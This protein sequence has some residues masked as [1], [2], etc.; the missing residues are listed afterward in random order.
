VTQIVSIE[1]VFHIGIDVSAWGQ[2][3]L[4]EPIVNALKYYKFCEPT[5]V[6]TRSLPKALEGRD[7]I[8]VAETVKYEQKSIFLYKL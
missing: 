8:G 1:Y 4:C 7:I 6:Q 5:Q 2:L 3:D